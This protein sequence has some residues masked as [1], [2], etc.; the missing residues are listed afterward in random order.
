MDIACAEKERRVLRN[1][2]SKAEANDTGIVD[3]LIPGLFTPQANKM[4]GPC[5]SR[6]F[7]HKFVVGLEWS[8]L[9]L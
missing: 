6:N 1:M 5:A 9:I 4:R 3:T 8:A 2:G 7:M